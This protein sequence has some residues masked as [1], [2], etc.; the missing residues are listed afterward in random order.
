MRATLTLWLVA[1]AA[2]GGAGAQAPAARPA[3]ARPAPGLSAAD[4]RRICAE[5]LA[6]SSRGLPPRSPCGPGTGNLEGAV[7]QVDG[8]P[9]AQAFVAAQSTC[10]MYYS[11]SGSDG[12]FVLENLPAG[13]YLVAARSRGT[14]VEAATEVVAGT[15]ARV[16]LRLGAPAASDR[17]PDPA[18]TQCGCGR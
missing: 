11:T 3:P 1:T 6:Q 5:E 9:V 17:A 8:T 2:C 16:D 4:C 14:L 7:A 12:R 15:P 10:G 13:P 18:A